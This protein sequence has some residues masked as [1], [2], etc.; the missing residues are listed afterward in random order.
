LLGALA[1]RRV[2]GLVWAIIVL[3]LTVGSTFADKRVALIIGNSDYREV[4]P[5]RNPRND[6]RDVAASLKK[7][8]F[9]PTL[10]L[11]LDKA[12]FEKAML[13]FGRSVLTADVAL[14][15]YAGHAMEL[16]G[17]NYLWPVEA[18][19]KG[20]ADLDGLFKVENLKQVMQQAGG[21]RILILDACRDNPF[22]DQLKRSLAGTSLVR[23]ASIQRGLAPIEDDGGDI[24]IM[25]ATGANRTADDGLGR[26]S[27]FTTAFLKNFNSPNNF[28]PNLTRIQA[29][30]ARETK[31]KQRPL[32][33]VQVTDHTMRRYENVLYASLSP[34]T[35]KPANTCT[36]S[37]ADFAYNEAVRIRT[38]QAF[39]EF[40]AKCPD[41]PRREAILKLDRERTDE[42]AW[43]RAVRQNTVIGY[44]EYISLFPSGRYLEDAKR[45]EKELRQP[46]TTTPAMVVPP[47][48]PRAEYVYYPATDFSGDDLNPGNPFMLGQTRDSCASICRATASCRAFTFNIKK[49]AC[50]LKAGFGRQIADPNA[51]SAALSSDAG[52]PQ[53]LSTAPSTSEPE[54]HYRY[55]VDFSGDDLNP[56]DPY[57]YGSSLS[58][59]AAT[60]RATAGCRAFTFNSQRN[61]CILKSGTGR[62]KSDPNAI[63]ASLS[64]GHQQVR[65]SS[66]SARIDIK[67]GVD[68]AG[69]DLYDRRYISLNQCQGLCASNSQCVAFSYV[70]TKTWCWLK[71]ELTP[72]RRSAGVVSG[73][74]Y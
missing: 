38:A 60:C 51:V 61:A 36:T 55:G 64:S 43:D 57:K 69:G 59:C 12:G 27:P 46:T 24:I 67:Y 50:I 70:E 16:K 73:A 40:L 37:D 10:H 31:N 32:L 8:G 6:A 21:V 15:Y 49:D 62:P 11:D 5:L 41:D 42:E 19:L 35:E 26:N 56:S 23:G 2:A 14:V 44:I 48:P 4:L 45:K 22:V 18:P 33:S 58:S 1:M 28:I 66:S 34:P 39:R 47:P 3:L 7:I 9:E 20:E 68:Y 52:R 53:Q 74:K 13:E 30:V 71:K 72:P 65:P 25:F 63:S 54:L 17:E 29:D